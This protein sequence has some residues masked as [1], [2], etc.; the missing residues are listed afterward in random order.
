AFMFSAATQMAQVYMLR[1]QST[2]LVHSLSGRLDWW[3]SAWSKILERPWLGYGAYAGGRFVVL[4]QFGDME[5]SSIH[6]SYV[7][8]VL[9]SGIL[10]VLPLLAALA[11]AWREL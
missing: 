11:G 9:G 4:A 5:T 2:E 3:E 1:G 8:A 6:N 7:E 10:G